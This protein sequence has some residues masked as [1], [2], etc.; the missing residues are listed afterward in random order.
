[1][2]V[3]AGDGAG[4]GGAE[5]G[6]RGASPPSELRIL[7]A[8]NSL[9]SFAQTKHGRNADREAEK[10]KEQE[11]WEKKVGI[12]QYLGQTVYDRKG[13]K[14]WYEK[15]PGE[16]S[17]SGKSFERHAIHKARQADLDPLKQMEVRGH[18]VYATGEKRV[19]TA[20]QRPSHR[21]SPPPGRLKGAQ[22]EGRPGA[23]EG[24]AAAPGVR[25]HGHP[26]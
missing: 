21:S 18:A 17:A 26:L 12:L 10:K 5:H 6:W 13:D 16:A 23:A 3:L 25:R 11:A 15:R 4:C 1:M 7:P 14:P 19:T 8:P 9:L 2:F 22:E 24:G 20:Q